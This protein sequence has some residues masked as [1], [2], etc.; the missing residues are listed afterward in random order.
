MVKI[1]KAPPLRSKKAEECSAKVQVRLS[2]ALNATLESWYVANDIP[3]KKKSKVISDAIIYFSNSPDPV[4]IVL[5]DI[6]N[7]E[8]GIVNKVYNL[9]EEAAVSLQGLVSIIEYIF[10]N[11]VDVTSK[12]IRAAIKYL[13][14]RDSYEMF[15]DISFMEE[16]SDA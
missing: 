5:S 15:K 16:E 2:T 4:E 11:Y 8:H 7:K 14:Y 13:V 1:L 10:P 6:L 9:S 3:V 12:A